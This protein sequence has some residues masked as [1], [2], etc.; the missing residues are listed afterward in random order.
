[1]LESVEEFYKTLN[2]NTGNL[3][4]LIIDLDGVFADFVRGVEDMTGEKFD[5][6]DE[7]MFDRLKQEIFKNRFFLNLKPMKDYMTLWKF[8]K[9]YNPKVLTATGEHYTETVAKEKSLWVRRFLGSDVPFYH[10]VKSHEK[11]KYARPNVLLID[12]RKKSIDPFKKAGGQV[13][14]HKNASS[15]VKKLKTLGFE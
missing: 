4:E 1:M 2:E 3:P 5:A 6:S 11:A 10:V 9:K 12:D 13:I 8:V 7:K 14:L 15:T